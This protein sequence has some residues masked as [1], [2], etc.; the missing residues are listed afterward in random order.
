MP[1]A[2]L[3]GDGVPSVSSCSES[4]T[5][6][7]ACAGPTSTCADAELA[8]CERGCSGG[9][10]NAPVSVTAAPLRSDVAMSACSDGSDEVGA[11]C[12]APAADRL[13]SPSCANAYS[14]A[15]LWL[16]CSTLTPAMLLALECRRVGCCMQCG[17]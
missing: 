7:R 3:E 17:R 11:D 2:S 10:N 1:A 5:S 12:P 6:A 16:A 8:L 14:E 9:V 15:L 13:R 4:A